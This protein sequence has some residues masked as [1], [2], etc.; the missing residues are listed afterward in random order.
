MPTTYILPGY[1]RVLN[2]TTGALISL[3]PATFSVSFP[4]TVTEV[5]YTVAP[6]GGDFV[7]SEVT[8]D[9]VEV[10][11]NNIVV[12]DLH[13][14]L[15]PI[16]NIRQ[17]NWSDGPTIIFSLTYT[18]FTPG[19]GTTDETIQYLFDA[20]LAPL[21]TFA[22]A[23]EFETF[24][25]SQFGSALDPSVVPT[26]SFAPGETIPLQNFAWTSTFSSPDALDVSGTV[27]PEVIDGAFDNDNLSGL[28]G[29]DTLNGFGGDDTLV[30]GIG[31]DV[32]NGG[33]G[34]DIAY[35]DGDQSSFTLTISPTGTVIEDRR[36][37]SEGRDTLDSI[38]VLD[39][40]NEI[41]LFGG[42]PMQLDR[43]DGPASLSAE[44]FA[45]ITELYI[46]YFN[47]APDAVGLY[48]WATEFAGG[49]SIADMA[50]QFFT[51]V[52]TRA[53]YADAI[54]DD[55]S[56]LTDVGAFVSAVFYTV[57]GRAFDEA[58][59]AFWTGVLESGAVS[60]ASFILEIIKGAK[61]AAPDDATQEFR[62][63]K[64]AD[65][66]YLET[67]TDIGAYFAVIKGMSDVDNAG[68]AMALYDGSAESVT[69]TVSAI[70]G[71]FAD[72]LVPSTAEFLMP[73]VG[74]IDDPFA[75]G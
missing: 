36:N 3:A 75:A 7:M 40:L 34:R 37:L 16:F 33:E 39:F 24:R 19:G 58:G 73:L 8:P 62:D 60:P 51:Q 49:F 6:A 15:D 70:D 25:L 17:L 11:V 27:N 4:N 55:G 12:Q 56:T 71:F 72:A 59:R 22:N 64:A 20:G 2:D 67:K 63:Q 74:V 43:F 18:D 65:I 14:P 26:G 46:A 52:E 38:E 21:P 9:A 61:A 66:A 53:T 29:N 23:E 35:F 68:A 47:R 5:S 10:A 57:L 30:G 31:D 44:D 50:V 45:E 48:F 69:T 54:S 28:A 1:Q 41:P 42:Q 32:L 13:S